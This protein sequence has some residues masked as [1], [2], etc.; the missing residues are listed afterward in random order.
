[1]PLNSPFEEL[2]DLYNDILT[3][4]L[5]LQ[6]ALADGQ[7]PKEMAISS[8]EWAKR[9]QSAEKS[10]ALLAVKTGPD[11]LTLAQ[12]TALRGQL[13]E[14][15]QVAEALA[16]SYGEVRASI[17]KQSQHIRAAKMFAGDQ[18][19]VAKGSLLNSKA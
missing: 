14:I 5:A 19:H 16:V 13:K 18:T 8:G 6:K 2:T 12:K 3:R 10:T 17:A 15:R 7:K 9:I 11:A 4:G 1:M